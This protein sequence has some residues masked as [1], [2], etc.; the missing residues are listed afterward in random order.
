MYVA[1]SEDVILSKLEWA[2]MSESDRQIA[3]VTGILRTQG[4]ALDIDYIERWVASLGLV[5]QW[6]RARTA[7]G[8]TPR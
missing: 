6:N 7:A 4:D 3:D 1:S 8:L 2:K 5:E